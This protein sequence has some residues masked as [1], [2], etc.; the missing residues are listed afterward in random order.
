MSQVLRLFV[1][2][3]VSSLMVPLFSLTELSTVD[4][5]V[6]SQSLD[7]PSEAP[8]VILMK[9]ERGTTRQQYTL[10]RTNGSDG[11][12]T[13]EASNAEVSLL[14]R[15]HRDGTLISALET[16][17]QGK[18]FQQSVD[19]ARNLVQTVVS[20]NGKAQSERTSSLGP[21]FALQ[22]E[23]SNVV[24]Q[25]WKAGIR[26]GLLLKSLSPDGGLVGDF[27]IVFLETDNPLALST[28]Y[29]YPEEFRKA[30]PVGNYVVADMSLVGFA[31]FFFPHHFY[32]AYT[33]GPK[34][35]EFV[36]YYGENPKTAMYQFTPR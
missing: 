2:V 26:D 3:A 16:T 10:R 1:L 6:R 32:L 11:T 24:Y 17:S 36:A 20:I 18:R 15:F 21:G 28:K 27:Q 35:L 23:I 22:T 19:E 31:A 4:Q 34:G 5:R 30:V 8:L 14:Q 7:L 13:V 33:K 9:S 25:A 29:D 12:Y